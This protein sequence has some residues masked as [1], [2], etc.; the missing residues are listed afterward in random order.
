MAT[1]PRDEREP[2]KVATV[3]QCAACGRRQQAP[4]ECGQCGSPALVKD[5]LT[6]SGAYRRSCRAAADSTLRPK[7]LNCYCS[8]HTVSPLPRGGSMT[9]QPTTPVAVHVHNTNYATAEATAAAAATAAPATAMEPPVLK[10]KSTLTAYAFFALTGIVGWHRF[11]LARPAFVWLGF[12]YV[13]TAIA[14]GTGN[15]LLFCGVAALLG[16]DLVEIPGWVRQYNKLAIGASGAAAAATPRRPPLL[17]GLGWRGATPSPATP[18]TTPSTPVPTPLIV[19]GPLPASAETPQPDPPTPAPV[20]PPKDLRTLLL[21]EA[22]RGDGR[23]TVTQGVMATGMD[24]ERVETCLRDMVQAGYVD[25][26]NEPGSGVI[27]YVFHELAGRPA[28][29]THGEPPGPEH[30]G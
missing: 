4:W 26:D 10:V 19:Q 6:R 11:Y 17:R 12:L 18:I 9:D 20:A 23:L 7:L 5:G 24:W 15:S 28:S 25:V 13:Q 14:I 16:V 1:K 21:H 30:H 3:Y 8:L 27:V 22:H 29:A 2:R